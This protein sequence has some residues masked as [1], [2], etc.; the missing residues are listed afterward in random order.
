MAVRF[1]LYST[2]RAAS[3]TPLT[4]DPAPAT[5]IDLGEDPIFGD[6]DP[7]AGAKGRGT[8]IATLGGAVDQDFGSFVADGRI[9]LSVQNAPIAA[10]TIAA[11]EAAFEAV[12]TE[13]YFTQGVDCW[14]VKFV[15]P[16]GFKAWRNLFWKSKSE[17]V[18][19]YELF[20]K[21]TAKSI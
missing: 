10:A 3:L 21:I 16:D 13:Y 18:F 2:D 4:L 1:V 12:D 5:L 17:D 8:R 20:L 7:N 14:K 15:K 19:S 11:L 6:F 9:R